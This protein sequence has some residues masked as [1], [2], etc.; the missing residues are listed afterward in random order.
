MLQPHYPYY[1]AG[2][3]VDANRDLAVTDKYSGEVATYVAIADAEAI[4]KG[5]AAAAAAMPEM[6]KLPP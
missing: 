2:Q 5:I 6:R 4:D 3:P 1:L